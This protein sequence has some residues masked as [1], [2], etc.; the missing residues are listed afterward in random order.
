MKSQGNGKSFIRHYLYQVATLLTECST[1]EIMEVLELL[2]WA[3]ER[4]KKIFTFGNGG[5]AAAASHLACDLSKG[6]I[7][8]SEKR[9]KVICLTDNVPLM[10]AWANDEDYA[11]I[12]VENLDP[13]LENEDVVFGI[14]GSGNSQNVIRAVD[15]GNDR[16]AHTVGLTGFDGGQLVQRADISITVP[17]DNMQQIEDAHMIVI[18]LLTSYLRLSSRER[19]GLTI[20]DA[21]EI[22]HEI[23]R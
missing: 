2:I 16:K 15:L 7:G 8:G 5:S 13:L 19:K 6:T 23:T 21:I 12:F 4:G 3:R 1:D 18:H 9:F 17:S 22:E 20:P 11:D 10:T 14:S